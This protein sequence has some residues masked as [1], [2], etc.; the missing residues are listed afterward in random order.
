MKGL[1][2][3]FKCNVLY[4]ESGGCVQASNVTCI[5]NKLASELKEA[6]ALKLK[7]EAM[8]GKMQKWLNAAT[9]HVRLHTS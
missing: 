8:A 6:T 1:R 4:L 3:A 5:E 9:K 2:R 7:Y